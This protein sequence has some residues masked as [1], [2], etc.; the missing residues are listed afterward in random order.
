M[1]IMKTALCATL[2][3][4]STPAFAGNAL[5]TPAPTSKPKQITSVMFG[6]QRID[7]YA[8]TQRA[9]ADTPFRQAYLAECQNYSKIMPGYPQPALISVDF[10]IAF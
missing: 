8:V 1:G 5:H 4:Y 10:R 7:M 3:C 6:A 9:R 2:L